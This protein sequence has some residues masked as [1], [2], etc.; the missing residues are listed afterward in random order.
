MLLVL[1]FCVPGTVLR[2]SALVWVP[3]KQILRE[4]VRA[5][6]LLRRW[7]WKAGDWGSEIGSTG[8]SVSRL[9][10]WAPGVT[11]LEPLGE[12]IGPTSCIPPELGGEGEVRKGASIYLPTP[13][14]SIGVKHRLVVS[15]SHAVRNI[16][17]HD[18]NSRIQRANNLSSDCWGG[19][20]GIDSGSSNCLVVKTRGNVWQWWMPRGRDMVGICYTLLL[21]D[22]N[23][24]W[25]GGAYRLVG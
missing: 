7:F 12:A 20:V 11:L 19:G 9:L 18:K 22:I 1:E 15:P 13:M 6:S 3:Q 4:C 25:P 5:S 8:P 14:H 2:H 10:L 23:F 24:P 16:R 17:S 21:G